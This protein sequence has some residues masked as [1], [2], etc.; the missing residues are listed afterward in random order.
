MASPTQWTWVW[1]NSRSWWWTGRLGM[2]QS[3]GSQRVGYDWVAELNWSW[4]P[5][6]S[7]TNFPNKHPFVAEGFSSGSLAAFG[8]PV[9]LVFTLEQFF[10]LSS[11]LLTLTLLRITGRLFLGC[12]Q[13]GFPWCFLMIRFRAFIFDKDITKVKSCVSQCIMLG[14]SQFWFVSLT[15]INWLRWFLPSFSTVFCGWV[16]WDY[17]N[18]PLLLKLLPTS[19]NVLWLNY[20]SDGR[21]MVIFLSQC[22]GKAF[23]SYLFIHFLVYINMDSWIFILLVETYPQLGLSRW[24]SGKERRRGFD[25]WVR[26]IPWR[27]K[28][29]H[30]PIFLPGESHGQRSLVGYGPWGPKESD[31]T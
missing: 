2:L 26:K 29:Q 19:F 30:T 20:Y 28:W 5:I 18:C 1:V 17:V 9:S 7:F 25:P 12:L 6:S 3:M 31:M 13:F 14:G 23:S 22:L 27:K 11:T 15:W 21:H 4:D 16:L 8:S 10:C 24:L